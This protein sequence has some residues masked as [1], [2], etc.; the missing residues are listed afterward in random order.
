MAWFE[1]RLKALNEERKK[2]LHAQDGAGWLSRAHKAV[3]EDWNDEASITN[4]V[5]ASASM[6][7]GKLHIALKQPGGIA[8]YHPH[9]DGVKYIPNVNLA[10]PMQLG[11][12]VIKTERDFNEHLAQSVL[13]CAERF[14][15]LD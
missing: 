10:G 3:N 12:E 15:L 4:K 7:D 13:R 8:D 1:D 6:A 2:R 9:A 14:N 11:A 5:G